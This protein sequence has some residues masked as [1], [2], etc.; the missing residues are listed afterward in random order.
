LLSLLL[1]DEELDEETVYAEVM[2]LLFATF[3]NFTG[4]SF[5]MH[6]FAELKDVQAKIRNEVQHVW[7]DNNPT[8]L[9]DLTRLVYT[10][11]A[12][13][14]A[15]RHGGSGN[16]NFRML[17]QD[18]LIQ[19]KYFIP[20]GTSIVTPVRLLH[21]NPSQWENPDKFDPERFMSF[22]KEHPEES[23]KRSRLAYIP[24]G[25]GP[26]SCLGQRYAIDTLTLTIGLLTRRFDIDAV[27]KGNEIT[28]KETIFSDQAVGG[29]W[30]KCTPRGAE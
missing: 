2:T 23:S 24:F 1:E 10:R 8:K 14:E 17:T 3:D 5:V 30:L 6:K 9:D 4:L 27:R 29:L 15:L 13:K 20:K 25:F 28:W 12:I 19:N 18:Y 16:S 11:A 7:G 26:R 22:D 21:K